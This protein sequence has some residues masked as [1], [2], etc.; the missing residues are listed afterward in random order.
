M[1]LKSR[2]RNVHNKTGLVC[3]LRASSSHPGPSAVR[4]GQRMQ[5]NTSHA[6]LL[7]GVEMR[8]RVLEDKLEVSYHISHGNTK[9]KYDITI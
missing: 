2:G 6:T 9:Y 5:L 3:G 7:N 8:E 1:F 4:P